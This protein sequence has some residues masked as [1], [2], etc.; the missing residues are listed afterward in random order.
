MDVFHVSHLSSYFNPRSS[1]EE[2]HFLTYISSPIQTN[3][4]P[5]SS[6]EE[7]HAGRGE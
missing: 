1:C 7:R 2:R 3:F 4:N 6:C 5:R